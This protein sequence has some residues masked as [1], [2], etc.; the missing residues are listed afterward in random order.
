[1]SNLENLK[2]QA[3]QY[4]RWHRDQYYPV[5]AMI[6]EHVP[7]FQELSDEEILAAEF[8][9]ADA[10]ELVARKEGFAGWQALRTG[11]PT[12]MSETKR[13]T[14]AVLTSIAPLLFVHDFNASVDFFTTK[15]GFAVDFTYGDPPFYGQVSRDHALMALRCVCE[16]VFAGDI[17]EREGLLSAAITVASVDEIKELFL[18]YQAAEVPF[19]QL[20]KN[21]PWGAKTFVVRDLDGNLI[22]FA[23]PSR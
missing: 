3:K 13:V 8:R 16:P 22:L 23:G 19:Q 9:L 11:A 10:Q 15:L 6:R 20:L 14:P 7:R 2:K 18:A 4:L 1:M 12:A 17:R 21:E 5:A